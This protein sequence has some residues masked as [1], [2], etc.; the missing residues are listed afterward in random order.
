MAKPYKIVAAVRGD[1]GHIL[2]SYSTAY[3]KLRPAL[4]AASMY[5]STYGHSTVSKNN[6]VLMRCRAA[7]AK[8]KGPVRNTAHFTTK[9]FTSCI[10]TPAGRVALADARRRARRS[11]R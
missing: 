3:A 8:R 9:S 7:I 5:A 1:G 10:P 4:K 11:R 2:T 6:T